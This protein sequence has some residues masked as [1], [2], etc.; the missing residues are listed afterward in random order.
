MHQWN[1]QESLGKVTIS[2]TSQ[3]K[4]WSIIWKKRTQDSQIW[5][6]NG[7]WITNSSSAFFTLL[8]ITIPPL[9]II[10]IYYFIKKKKKLMLKQWRVINSNMLFIHDTAEN[11]DRIMVL[12]S[13]PSPFSIINRSKQQ[14]L[15]QS[16]IISKFY[17]SKVQL[18]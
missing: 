5:E 11:E 2:S 14:Q 7:W 13:W 17:H 16:C 12:S 6:N 9:I 3:S 10:N 8:S 18:Q 1:S 4:S 15:R